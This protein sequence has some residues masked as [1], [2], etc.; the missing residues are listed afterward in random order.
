MITIESSSEQNQELLAFSFLKCSFSFPLF[1]ADGSFILSTQ[2]KIKIKNQKCSFTCIY[3]SS[4]SDR[5]FQSGLTPISKKWQVWEFIWACLG[6]RSK[7][8]F[9]MSSLHTPQHPS[10]LFPRIFGPSRDRSSQFRALRTSTNG[11]SCA[12]GLRS[13]L[14]E[15]T[16]R[17]SRVSR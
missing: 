13:V 1:L 8:E 11:I 3:F 14:V 16:S 7:R 4:V 2:N 9:L 12:A 15:G 17:R 5:N 10:F 6:V